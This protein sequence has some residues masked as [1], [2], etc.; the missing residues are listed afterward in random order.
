MSSAVSGLGAYTGISETF[1]ETLHVAFV[2]RCGQ[3]DRRFAFGRE[4]FELARRGDRI[5]EQE[6]L[7]V[8]DRVRGDVLVP[9]LAERQSGCGAVQCQRPGRNSRTARCY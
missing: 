4:P 1:D 5:E 6:A 2:P 9:R 8:V 7:A 3:D